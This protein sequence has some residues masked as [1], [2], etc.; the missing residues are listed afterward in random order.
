MGLTLDDPMDTNELFIP[1]HDLRKY[2]KVHKSQSVN[3][4]VQNVVIATF[5]STVS[6]F[7]K[8]LI[9]LFADKLRGLTLIGQNC[10]NAGLYS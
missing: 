9:K 4:Y 1:I 2:V 7:K 6:G 10:K 8:T 3:I 5:R